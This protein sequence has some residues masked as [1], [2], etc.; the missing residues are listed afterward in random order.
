[1]DTADTEFDSIKKIF[2]LRAGPADYKSRKM[3]IETAKKAVE[4]VYNSVS[5][6]N[7]C[8]Q[9]MLPLDKKDEMAK[10]VKELQKRMEVL[11]KTEQ[12]LTIIEDFNNRL[13]VFDK[14]VSEMEAWLIEARKKIDEI[15]DQSTENHFSP[16]DR[17]VTL[18]ILFI[19]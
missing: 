16:E 3:R 19:Q 11:N 15:L 9:A 13:I 1:M 6:C 10:Q 2:D 17:F 14:E 18:L 7:D 12:K 5:Q 8:I 4:E